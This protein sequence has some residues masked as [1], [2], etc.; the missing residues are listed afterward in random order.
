VPLLLKENG[1][2]PEFEATDDSVALRMYR[3]SAPTAAMEEGQ[4]HS[5]G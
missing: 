1:V 4:D 2:A 3:G 5:S